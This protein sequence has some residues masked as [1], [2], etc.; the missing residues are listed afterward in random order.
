MCSERITL[1]THSHRTLCQIGIRKNPRMVPQGGSWEESC[2]YTVQVCRALFYIIL[3]IKTR[4]KHILQVNWGLMAELS[5]SSPPDSSPDL[6]PTPS[7]GSWRPHSPNPLILQ[8]NSAT[9]TQLAGQ[10]PWPCGDPGQS[11]L[12]ISGHDWLSPWSCACPGT[13]WSVWHQGVPQQ[14]LYIYL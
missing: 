5:P 10:K 12:A 14:L 13:S 8:K 9:H 6:A 3:R 4:R 7:V 1:G 2:S 11:P